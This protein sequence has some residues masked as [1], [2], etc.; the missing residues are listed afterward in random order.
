MH[1]RKAVHVLSWFLVQVDTWSISIAAIETNNGMSSQ[2]T[3][4]DIDQT[5]ASFEDWN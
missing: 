1:G 2:A 4:P 5:T 3:I